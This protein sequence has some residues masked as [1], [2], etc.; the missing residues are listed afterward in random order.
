[1]HL[2]GRV[3][4]DSVRGTQHQGL[5]RHGDLIPRA[6]REDHAI[7]VKDIGSNYQLIARAISGIP[8][9]HRDNQNLVYIWP[10]SPRAEA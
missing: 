3:M 4:Q 2:I 10:R 9:G 1:M 5:I 8:P 6:L 7:L